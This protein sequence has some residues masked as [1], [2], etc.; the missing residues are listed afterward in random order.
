MALG[1]GRP[2]VVELVGPAGVGKT[3]LARQ[4]EASGQ[5]AR[6][7]MWQVPTSRLARGTVRQLPVA[8]TLYRETGKFLWNE[9][10]HFARLDAL[11]RYLST[12]RWNGRRFIVL[13]EGPVFTLSYLQVMG[14]RRFQRSPAP[15]CWYRTLQRW[16][17][18]L[19]AI[20]VLDAPDDVLTTRIRT[21]AQPHLLKDS[22]AD[23]VSAFSNAYR[24]ATERVLADWQAIGVA[25]PKVL[26][27]NVGEDGDHLA[28]RL[29]DAFE[30][31]THA[32]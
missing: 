15:A 7:T 1:Q 17:G 20:V 5:G 27:L 6:G 22:S 18:C 14:D 28:E 3:T 32:R 21:R 12:Q 4:L 2:A 24:R 29:L 19:D 9:I 11:Y 8:L 26:R 31:A 25:P 16:S 23:E 10:K 13:D 30:R